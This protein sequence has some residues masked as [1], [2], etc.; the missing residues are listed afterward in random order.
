MMAPGHLAVETSGKSCAV[1]QDQEYDDEGMNAGLSFSPEYW[2]EM[3]ARRALR[4]WIV[5]A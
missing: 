2:S 4:E 5:N 3:L 1:K